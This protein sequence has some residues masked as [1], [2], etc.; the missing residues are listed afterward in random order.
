MYVF[1]LFR[2]AHTAH[3]GSQARRQIAAVA[4][5]LHQ[6]HSNAGSEPRLWP[7]P[8]FTATPDP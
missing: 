6:S 2:A 1:C 7:T 4:A 5:G 8:Q 3:R